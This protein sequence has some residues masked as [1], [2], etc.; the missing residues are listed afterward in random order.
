MAYDNEIKLSVTAFE[1]KIAFSDD[2]VYYGILKTTYKDSKY[3]AHE[4][5]QLLNKI[6]SSSE[7]SSESSN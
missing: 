4:W 5:F 6:K 2:H 1:S 3:T 7:S